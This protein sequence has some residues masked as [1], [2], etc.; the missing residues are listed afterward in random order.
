MSV[1]GFGAY[2][3]PL[4]MAPIPVIDLVAVKD[5]QRKRHPYAWERVPVGTD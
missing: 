2:Q 4:C 5:L 3:H 1:K